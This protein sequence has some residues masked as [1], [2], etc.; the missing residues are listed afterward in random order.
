MIKCSPVYVSLN[1]FY[2]LIWYLMYELN[3]IIIRFI[4]KNPKVV[5]KMSKISDHNPY[6]QEGIKEILIII[7]CPLLWVK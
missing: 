5:I 3:F 1:N 4:L 7:V 2:S 6:P